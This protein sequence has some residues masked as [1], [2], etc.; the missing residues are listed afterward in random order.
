[1][2]L[3]LLMLIYKTLLKINIF[4]IAEAKTLKKIKYRPKLEAALLGH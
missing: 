2:A 4:H 3:K 1:M